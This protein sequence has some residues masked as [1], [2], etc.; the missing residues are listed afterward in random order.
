MMFWDLKIWWLLDIAYDRHGRLTTDIEMEWFDNIK[1]FQESENVSIHFTNLGKGLTIMDEQ[2][3]RTK[4]IIHG[5]EVLGS[6]LHVGSRVNVINKNTCDQLGIRK[7]E[8]CPFWLRMANTSIVWPIELIWQLD[9]VIGK[10]TFQ[11]LGVVL[12]LD[13][14]G[15]YP[16]LFGRPW[17][18]TA[19]IEQIW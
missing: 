15:A 4:V 10:H 3:S 14:P 1:I 2:S 9:I 12:H 5:Q 8:A 16:L 13:A 11:I 17:L 19:N 6:I 18:W 7:W